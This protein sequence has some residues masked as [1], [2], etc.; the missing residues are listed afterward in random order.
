VP[1]VA[2][3]AH[4]AASYRDA[5]LTAG[6]D[7]ML[8]KPYTLEECAQVV[9][10][11]SARGALAAS[12]RA[13]G[14]PLASVDAAAVATLRRL[15]SDERVDLYSKLVELFQAGAAPALAQLA[16]TLD[17]ADLV[18]AA[19]ICHRFGS[20]AANVGANAFARDVRELERLCAAG[21]APRARE[22]YERLAAAYP[23]LIEELSALRLR[24]SA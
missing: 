5:C 19:A 18:A 4:D 14:D 2:L 8:S 10:R 12:T 15:R 6:M 16:A 24:V 20:S 9:R 11:F 7:D 21:E 13:P 22:L 3:T 1:I 17:A 23:A